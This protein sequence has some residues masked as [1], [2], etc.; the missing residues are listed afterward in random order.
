MKS[1]NLA[2][3]LEIFLEILKYHLKSINPYRSPEIL[4][5][6]NPEIRCEIS[7]FQNLIYLLI[8]WRLQ[9]PRVKVK[10]AGSFHVTRRLACTRLGH[11]LQL[12]WKHINNTHEIYWICEEEVSGI[13]AG[14]V[15][16]KH[17]LLCHWKYGLKLLKLYV[18]GNA[19]NETRD[20]A[21][22]SKIAQVHSKQTVI[23]CGYCTHWGATQSL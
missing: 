5:P 8:S 9:A 12:V 21:K 20:V 2:Q 3:N 7:R 6:I 13:S 15:L 10:V 1:W 4:L 14:R 23:I 22:C 11:W 19:T 18:M 16:V 17:K